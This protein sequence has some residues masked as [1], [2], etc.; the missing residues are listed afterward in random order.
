MIVS[1]YH[2]I[3]IFAPKLFDDDRLG[4]SF[5]NKNKKTKRKKSINKLAI[6]QYTMRFDLTLVLG[7]VVA[8]MEDE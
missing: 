7:C 1:K 4:K 3:Y 8:S 2:Y 5:V 6:D